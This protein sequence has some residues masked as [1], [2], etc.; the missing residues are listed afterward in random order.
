MIYKKLFLL[1]C[2]NNRNTSEVNNTL[3]KINKSI[4]KSNEDTTVFSK[5][6]KKTKI[7]IIAV[8]SLTIGI[9]GIIVYKNNKDKDK[10][11]D[12]T[13]KENEKNSSYKNNE[14]NKKQQNK[15][16][17]NLQ[18]EKKEELIKEKKTD[19]SDK[20]LEDHLEKLLLNNPNFF[21]S[22]SVKLD[23]I[24]KKVNDIEE[25]KIYE[26][27]KNIINKK[28]FTEET[29]EKLEAINKNTIGQ[30]NFYNNEK[31]ILDELKKHRTNN[32]KKNIVIYLDK[33]LENFLLNN[34]EFKKYN[35]DL[36]I[37]IKKRIVMDSRNGH[38]SN[39]I[40]NMIEDFDYITKNKIY[41]NINYH[42]TTPMNTN[43]KFIKE[44]LFYFNEYM[45]VYSKNQ[46]F[47]L[48]FSIY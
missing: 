14:K 15:N 25:D 19:F 3:E 18:T 26:N 34:E 42:I 9:I 8:T 7:L 28:N 20:E 36:K 46:N 21:P 31:E 24:L 12:N 10:D 38:M 35:K 44:V 23:E 48:T 1:F 16:L 11:K 5:I 40:K 29:F 33:D 2:L 39:I 45:K 27:I 37:Y 30:N 43:E 47:I 6:N 13:G 32:E 22:Q 4:F 17:N 41:K